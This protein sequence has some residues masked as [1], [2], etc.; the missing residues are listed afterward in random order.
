MYTA[1][2]INVCWLR[3]PVLLLLLAGA[4]CA[5]SDAAA[6]P[7][8]ARAISGA[9][10]P[11][12][13]ESPASASVVVARVQG[14][15]IVARELD[16]HQAATGLPRLEALED[17]VDLAL[18]GEAARTLGLPPVT[19]V[20]PSGEV[21][22]A[23]A[24]EVARKLSLDVPPPVIVLVVNHAWV[25]DAPQ[26]AN[27]AVERAAMERLRGL[28]VAGDSIP[29]AYPKLGTDGAGW[30]VG[31]REEYPYEVVPAAARDLPAGSLSPLISGNGGLHLFTILE[32]RPTR[33]A[34][35]LV[36]AALHD[37]LRAGKA[38]EIVEGPAP[39]AARIAGRRSDEK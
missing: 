7:P 22:D 21:R 2:M 3:S 15:P 23:L 16:A 37:E 25:K 1:R 29:N 32:R 30:H 39:P 13:V 5:T 18:L 6:P 28:V 9:A 26:A 24:Y 20:P 12:A 31:D 35:E 17:L 19:G 36:R 8:A 34:P 14:Q 27:R 10:S 38:I 4:G 33:P 11:T